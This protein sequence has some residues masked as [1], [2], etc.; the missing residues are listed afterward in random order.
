M[1]LPIIKK[2]KKGET[3]LVKC[4]RTGKLV[5]I[6]TV[7]HHCD[8]LAILEEN[9]VRCRWSELREKLRTGQIYHEI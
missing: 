4:P 3:E 9:I 1:K 7:C 8:D 2:G 6:H 5:D